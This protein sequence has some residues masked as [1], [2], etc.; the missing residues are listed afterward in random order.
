MMTSTLLGALIVPYLLRLA[1]NRPV[2]TKLWLDVEDGLRPPPDQLL[3]QI[4]RL[5]GIL[6]LW[7]TLRKAGHNHV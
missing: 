6:R 1:L 7:L 3:E 4:R 2:R 5:T